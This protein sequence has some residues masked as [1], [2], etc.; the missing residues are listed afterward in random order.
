MLSW[1]DRYESLG[2]YTS[3]ECARAHALL[4]AASTDQRV[5][6]DAGF[7]ANIKGT[8]AFWSVKFMTTQGKQVDIH[9]VHINRQ[10]SYALG[11]VSVEEDLIFTT[12]FA[13]IFDRLHNSDLVIDMDDRTYKCVWSNRT[14]QDI[15]VNETILFHRQISD[16]KSIIF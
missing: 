9:L 4:L 13:N 10:L 5:K 2:T 6:S 8:N 14:F 16:L 3:W 11:G 1:K 15:Q 12:D 7:T